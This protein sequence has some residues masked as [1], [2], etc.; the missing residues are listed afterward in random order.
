MVSSAYQGPKSLGFSRYASP[1]QRKAQLAAV[2]DVPV[3]LSSTPDTTIATQQQIAAMNLP[4][5][6]KPPAAELAMEQDT[7]LKKQIEDHTA[8]AT[9]AVSRA[10]TNTRQLL[11][12]LRESTPGSEVVEDL[13]K[14]LEQLFEIANDTK[15][16]L[17]E[18]MEKQRDNMS[19][20]HSSMMNETIR[21]TQDEL[22]LQHKKVN[23]QHNLILQ[24]Q[25]AFQQY[26]AQTGSKL[27]D[28]ENFQERVSRLTLEKGN[29]RTEVDKY[30][31]LLNREVAAKA[32]DA[33]T[34]VRLQKE[35][36]K[37][38]SLKEQLQV[39]NEVLCKKTTDMLD[40][41][42]STEQ[43]VTDRFTKQLKDKS[44]ELQRETVKTASLN[45]LVNALKSGEN[46]AKKELDK[47]KSDYR[48]L[49][50][51]YTNQASEHAAAFTVSL[52][53]HPTVYALL[54]TCSRS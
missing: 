43:K 26:K 9:R 49:N 47:I 14:E 13:W 18:F 7:V 37:L 40:Q 34:T 32:D 4:F 51:K 25:E 6:V 28:L 16:A 2:S 53:C 1:V 30:K 15:A 22:N 19:L 23:T 46:A 41:L 52:L 38:V 39:E 20:Y 33:K 42:K 45:T 11:G 50:S 12:L 17:P 21:E 5:E 29:F 35:V 3:S 36:E 27:D 24:Q 54:T 8:K 10:I 31:E 48:L 44:N